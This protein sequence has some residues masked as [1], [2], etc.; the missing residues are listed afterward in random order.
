[1]LK[2][3]P[4][5][6]REGTDYFWYAQ[7]MDLGLGHN[8]TNCDMCIYKRTWTQTFQQEQCETKYDCHIHS[9]PWVR[10]IPLHNLEIANK[11]WGE[12]GEQDLYMKTGVLR[13]VKVKGWPMYL[14]LVTCA[15]PAPQCNVNCY[16]HNQRMEKKQT[17]AQCAHSHG[18]S[19]S[20][21]FFDLLIPAKTVIQTQ[22]FQELN[23]QQP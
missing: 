12:Y 7:Q 19:R 22:F 1:M 3:F 23:S 8:D 14:M 18:C 2:F 16:F 20:G 17:V 11:P 10:L 4:K 9:Y 13:Q 15:D 5:T 6:R 21:S